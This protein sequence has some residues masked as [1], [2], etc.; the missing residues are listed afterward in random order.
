[1]PWYYLK[2]TGKEQREARLAVLEPLQRQTQEGTFK[3]RLGQTLEIAVMKSIERSGLNFLGHFADID[4]HDDSTAYTK[5]EP[6]IDISGKRIEKGRLDFVVFPAGECAGH[7]SRT[8]IYPRSAEIKEMLWKCADINAIP[9]LV[10]RRLLFITIR[11]LQMGG[12]LIHENYNQLYPTGDAALA[13]Q[14]RNKY[15]LGYHDVRTGNEPDA[16]MM[17]FMS[18]LLPELVKKAKPS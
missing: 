10:A 5:V 8:W 16:R 13:A 7:V 12:C 14:V 11:L 3:H 2:V 15:L 9:V 17:R 4:A 6:P 1:M 18:E